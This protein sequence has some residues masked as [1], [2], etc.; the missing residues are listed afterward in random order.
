MYYHFAGWSIEIIPTG[1]FK[2]VAKAALFKSEPDV[3]FPK[4]LRLFFQIAKLAAP[5]RHISI[6]ELVTVNPWSRLG[7]PEHN[8]PS[9][10]SIRCPLVY[11][12]RQTTLNSSPRDNPA[13]KDGDERR[14]RWLSVWNFPNP[15][16]QVV[17][18]SHW[19]VFGGVI[20]SRNQIVKQDKWH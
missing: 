2:S 12:G 11:L 10:L 19:E 18:P 14:E 7:T 13:E 1:H 9:Q 20:P 17:T 8:H 5:Q 3:N 15:L 4:H 16:E 6:H